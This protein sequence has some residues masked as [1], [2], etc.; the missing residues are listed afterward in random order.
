MVNSS[1][2]KHVCLWKHQKWME[3][4]EQKT[5]NQRNHAELGSSE[6]YRSAVLITWPRYNSMDY[7]YP[8]ISQWWDSSGGFVSSL[9]YI[10]YAAVRILYHGT[11]TLA[12]FQT[13]RF[14]FFALTVKHI[15]T[16]GR[17][18]HKSLTK[19]QYFAPQLLFRWGVL[20]E[21]IV[22]TS[23]RQ[24]ASAFLTTNYVTTWLKQK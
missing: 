22:N 13:T 24:E 17:D 4:L 9:L 1:A 15:I 14:V 2:D 10:E 6:H 11:G 23:L 3:R 7:S 12:F 16:S 20:L 5:V 8:G 19:F 21:F 18:F